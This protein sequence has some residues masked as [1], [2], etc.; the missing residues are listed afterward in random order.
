MNHIRK[1]ALTVAL[2]FALLAAPATQAETACGTPGYGHM[3]GGWGQGYG[4]GMK[5]GFDL[6]DEQRNKMRQIM[7]EQFK[8]NS[9]MREKMFEAHSQLEDLYDAEKPDSKAIDE[10]YDR[11]NTLHKQMFTAHLQA[12]GKMLDVLTD[13]QRKQWNTQRRQWKHMGYGPMGAGMGMM[14]PGYGYGPGMMGSGYGY[15]PMGPGMMGPGYGYGPMGP[16]MMGP[17][18]GPW[19]LDE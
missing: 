5:A 17:G 12:R 3:I 7:R 19:W 1:K 10:A 8:Q 2:S 4:P 13:E 9:E 16:G 18:Y 14:A 11:M 6:N 15:G